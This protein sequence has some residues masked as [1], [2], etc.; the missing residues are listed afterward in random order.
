MA[1]WSATALSTATTIA[2]I[3]SEVNDLTSSDWSNAIATAKTMIGSRLE[4]LLSQ[5]GIGVNEVDGEELL[6]CVVDADTI[7]GLCSDFL[8]LHLIY[9]DLA[10]GNNES[11]YHEKSVFYRAMFEEQLDV[12]IKRIKLDPNL[13]DTTDIYRS[14]WRQRFTR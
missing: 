11:S 10:D 1:D 8:T 6:D 5:R 3:E 12:D 4:N 9:N 7:F 13:D 2:K 14:N